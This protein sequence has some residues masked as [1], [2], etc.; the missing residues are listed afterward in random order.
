MP[1]E[2]GLAVAFMHGRGNYDWYVFE[3]KQRRLNK[4][5][6]DL[7]GTEVYVHGGR[8]AGVL[9]GLLNALI[10]RRQNPT[11]AELKR[12]FAIL[13]KSSLEIKRELGTNSLYGS[14]AFKELCIAAVRSAQKAMAAVPVR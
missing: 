11:F 5:L 14:R 8:P 3:E 4:S 13:K 12:A 1:F 7:D 6:S 2:L 9:R 10:R